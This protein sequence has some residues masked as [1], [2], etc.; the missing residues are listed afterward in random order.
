MRSVIENN[1][2]RPHRNTRA[3]DRLD[4]PAGCDAVISQELS[5]ANEGLE[6]SHNS[7]NSAHWS[8]AE[9]AY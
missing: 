3:G 5:I 2:S 9:T 6:A 7:G 1:W 4:V 8:V